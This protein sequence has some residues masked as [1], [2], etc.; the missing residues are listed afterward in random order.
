MRC[1]SCGCFACGAPCI[2]HRV[3]GGREGFVGVRVVDDADWHVG[4]VGKM[5]HCRQLRG[6]VKDYWMSRKCTIVYRNLVGPNLVETA[7]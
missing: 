7:C 5:G 3:G 4:E 1:R 6:M 2:L